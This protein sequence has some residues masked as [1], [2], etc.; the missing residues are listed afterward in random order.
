LF[1]PGTIYPAGLTQR[2]VEVLL[3]ICSASTDR[4]IADEF[5]ISFRTVGS[6]VKSIL[7]KTGAANRTEAVT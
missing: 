4:E 3:L 5:F 1:I 6:H 7:D 2:V